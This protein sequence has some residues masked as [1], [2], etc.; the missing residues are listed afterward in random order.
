MHMPTLRV[1]HILELIATSEAGYKLSEIAKQLNMPPSTLYPILQTLKN[2]RYLSYDETRQLYRMGI[3]IFELSNCFAD[4]DVPFKEVKK[5]LA[6]VARQCGETCHFGTLDGPDVLYV[7]KVDSA[8]PI[9]MYSSIGKKIPA[10]GTAIGKALLRDYSLD[11]LK[12]LYAAGLPKLTENSITDIEVLYQQLLELRQTGYAYE[13]EESN[14]M[15][16][17]IARPVCL[18]NKVEAAVSVAVPVFRFSEEKKAMIEG[19]LKESVTRLEK[20]M[21]YMK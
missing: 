11:E 1:L 13:K 5:I 17:C 3:K 14:E 7:A 9:R 12:N 21:P 15:I 2:K 16:T 20:L 18:D 10:S 8:E 4:S 19:L 6:D